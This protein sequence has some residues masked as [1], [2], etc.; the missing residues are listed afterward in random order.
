[1]GQRLFV[2]LQLGVGM[3]GP[4]EVGKM[5]V[6]LEEIGEF[7]FTWGRDKIILVELFRPGHGRLT[8]HDGSENPE[9]ELTEK[10]ERPAERD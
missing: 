7:I 2:L 1:M 9:I 3:G 6:E 8:V 10:A 5:H 4:F